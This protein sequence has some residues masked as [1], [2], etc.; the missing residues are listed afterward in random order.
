MKITTKKIDNTKVEVSFEVPAEELDR[1]VKETKTLA[2]ASDAL[3]KASWQ[4]AVKEKELEPIGPAQTAIEQ[5]VPGQTA[6]FKVTA[7]VLPE[8]KLP[9][10][11]S[12]VKEIKKEKPEIKDEDVEQ[13]IKSWQLS[14]SKF[15]ILE[16]PAAKGDFVHI[17]FS[18]SLFPGD[19]PQQDRF[20]LGEG[21][22]IPGFED[23]LVGLSAGE[24]KSFK[25]TYPEPYFAAHLAGKEAEFKVKMAK[26]EEVEKISLE[27][28]IQ[29]EKA[30]ETIEELRQKVR[31]DMERQAQQSSEQRW[32]Q[33]V[34][35]RIAEAAEMELPDTLIQYEQTRL[36]ESLKRQVAN[37]LNLPFEDYLKKINQKEED[38]KKTYRMEAERNVKHF[39]LIRA[40][41][42]AEK[43]ELSED[44]INQEMAKIKADLPPEQA[45]QVDQGQLRAY[46]KDALTRDKLFQKLSSNL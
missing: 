21:R 23:Q 7:P 31:V 5:M 3:I 36:V 12:L 26:V 34:I 38:L 24:E 6:K 46:T 11:H 8:V 19:Q 14:K 39:L 32:R 42:R 15:K 33:Q 37:Q 29:K 2:E 4:Q 43:I 1:H 16:R 45:E 41:Q 18:S 35:D 40:L 44:E 9:D 28:L 20:I 10:Y 25:L 27:E 13:A 22:L 17:E 30:A